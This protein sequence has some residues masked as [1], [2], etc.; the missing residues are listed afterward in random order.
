MENVGNGKIFHYPLSIPY[1]VQKFRPRLYVP[2]LARESRCCGGAIL[3]LHPTHHHAHVPGFDDDGDPKRLKR[4]LDDITDFEG[5]AF[6][7]L[8][9]AG[10]HIHDT[11]EFAQANDAAIGDI[12][13]VRLAKKGQH[14]VLAHGIH[15]YVFDDDHFGVVLF[16]H[17]RAQ[18]GSRVLG[19]ALGEELHG[20][21]RSFG[22]FQQPLPLGIFAHFMEQGRVAMFKDVGGG[23]VV[24]I[25][26]LVH[27]FEHLRNKNKTGNPTESR[28]E[29]H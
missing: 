13:N 1:Q 26:F 19:I 22:R 2:K 7:Y 16:E 24:S 14:V 9:A 11:G 4:I 28:R 10:K 8:Q 5:Q 29:K 12:S 25:S 17:G 18:N 3:L 15:L 21:G 23:L 6:L 20:L 27:C